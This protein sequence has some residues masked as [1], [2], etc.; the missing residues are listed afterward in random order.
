MNK[1]KNILKKIRNFISIFETDNFNPYNSSIFYLNTNSRSGLYFLNSLLNI[2]NFFFIKK[3]FLFFKESIYGLRYATYDIYKRKNFFYDKIIITWASKKNFKSNGSLN[4]RYLN[5]NSNKLKK[6]LWFIIY[7]DYQLPNKIDKNLVLL[8]PQKKIKLNVFKFIIFF[9]KNLKYL[10]R[11]TN[12]FLA[13]IINYN[14]FAF[15]FFEKIKGFLNSKI[16]SVF[17]LYEGQ[18]FQNLMIKKI[19]K[20]YKNIKTIGYVHSPPKAL[21]SNYLYNNNHS[22]DEIILNGKDQEYCF[23][24]QLGWKKDKIKILPSFRFLK[25]RNFLINKT[26][27]LPLFVIDTDKIINNLIYLHN[28]KFV[29]LTKYEIKSHPI[30]LKDNKNKILI[31]KMMSKI[32]QLKKPQVEIENNLLIFI[33]STGAIIEYLELGYDVIQI[34]ENPVFELYTSKLWP[35]IFTKKIKKNIYLYKI[36]NKNKL[37]ILGTNEHNNVKKISKLLN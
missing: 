14:F 31:K 13:S 3:Y 16:K 21:P 1:K 29:D 37:I 26:I 6:T 25:K 30:N 17:I 36:R 33:G 7:E 12:F 11:H 10:F 4:D 28:T 8:A 9:L 35:S 34:T 32:S 27:F 18:P 15:I 20:N 24:K 23:T 2:S 5:L 22:P 19:K